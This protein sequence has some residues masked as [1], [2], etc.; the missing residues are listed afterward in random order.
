MTMANAAGNKP[1]KISKVH[2]AIANGRSAWCS[3]PK[4]FHSCRSRSRP[5]TSG[6]PSCGT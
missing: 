3:T 6:L 2:Q 5:I 1:R 4:N